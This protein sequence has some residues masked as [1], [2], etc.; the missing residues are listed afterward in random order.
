M[1]NPR[2]YKQRAVSKIVEKFSGGGPDGKKRPWG[3][4][5]RGLPLTLIPGLRWMATYNFR[6]YL[7]DDVI[8]GITVGIMLVPQVRKRGLHLL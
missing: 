3:A 1:S 4:R 6:K 7:R 8:A 2:R 5:L